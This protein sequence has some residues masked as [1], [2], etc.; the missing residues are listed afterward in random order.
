MSRY[1][2]GPWVWKDTPGLAGWYRPTGTTSCIDLRSLQDSAG[3]ITPKGFGLFV[4][5]DL[6]DLGSDYEDLGND[7]LAPWTAQN[8]SK[9]ASAFKLPQSLSANNLR[10]ALW[11]TLTIQS[12]P[13]G[14]DRVKPLIPTTERIFEVWLGGIVLKK[15]PFNI[16]DPEAVP[17]LDLLKREY[18][19][20]RQDCLNGKL[21][22]ELYK[23]V[24]GFWVDKYGVDYRNFQP[25]DVPDEPPIKPTTTLTESFD[26]G[27]SS[28]LGPDQTWTEYKDGS[29]AD[30]FEVVSNMCQKRDADSGLQGDEA[31]AEADVSS[32]DHYA[33]IVIKAIGSGVQNSQAGAA[34]RFDASAATF[35]MAR[36]L[37]I[38]DTVS[39]DKASAGTITNINSAGITVAVDKLVKVQTNGSTVKSFWDGSETTSDTD[40]TI[41]GNTRGGLFAYHI[42]SVQPTARPVMDAWQMADLAAATGR[43]LEY[44]SMDGLRRGD[45]TGG[46]KG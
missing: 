31:R 33:Q 12:D 38:N 4:T 45:L 37:Q 32:S 20:V 2:F 19:S 43:L 18:R 10:D 8:K 13:L 7:P 21:Q 29:A 42:H 14:D 36:V 34:C 41:A 17:M 1:W 16:S 6:T 15:Q 35:Y 40:T 5:D 26:K 46:F 23:K 28:T 11:E 9:W 27:D 22:P 25:I 24:L 30:E 39:M 3:T 44:S